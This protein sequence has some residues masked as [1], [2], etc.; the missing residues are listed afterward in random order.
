MTLRNE[1]EMI[2][3][4]QHLA[5]GYYSYAEVARKLHDGARNHSARAYHART[6]EKAMRLSAK[7]ALIARRL[8]GV[9]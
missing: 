1:N 4:A 5:A 2:M 7:H 9:E 3:D 6:V 8:L